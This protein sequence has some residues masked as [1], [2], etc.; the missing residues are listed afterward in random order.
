[1]LP[2]GSVSRGLLTGGPSSEERS[3]GS[4]YSVHNMESMEQGSS[5]IVARCRETDPEIE[6]HEVHEISGARVRGPSVDGAKNKV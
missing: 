2:A 1:M 5:L 4:G 3:M 6:T